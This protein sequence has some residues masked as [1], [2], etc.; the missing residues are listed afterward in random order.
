MTHDVVVA[1]VKEFI[2]SQFLPGEDPS[3]LTPD[4]PLITGGILD[5]LATLEL[6]SFL[7]TKYVIELQAHEV[8]PARIG[9]L[10][11]VANLV[12]AKTNGQA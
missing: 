7:E 3:A 9:T 12:L 11:S 6:V 5:S 1:T 2:L 10:N 4:T 8:D